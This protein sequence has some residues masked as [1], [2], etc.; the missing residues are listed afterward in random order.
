M[1]QMISKSA[2]AKFK[3]Q[4][5]QGLEPR[6]L[7]EGAFDVMTSRLRKRMAQDQKPEGALPD[8]VRKQLDVLSPTAKDQLRRYLSK[9]QLPSAAMAPQQPPNGGT[10][11]SDQEIEE[12]EQGGDGL[13][14]KICSLLEEYGVDPSIIDRVRELAGDGTLS[15]QHEGDPP[16]FTTKKAFD[17]RKRTAR[18]EEFG[19]GPKR[20]NP[21]GMQTWAIDQ[22]EFPGVP[23]TDVPGP[24]EAS[25]DANR[26]LALD[27]MRRIRV[28]GPPASSIARDRRERKLAQDARDRTKPELGFLMRFPEASRFFN[29]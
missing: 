21:A 15:L 28:D 2:L 17:R 25:G 13:N 5:T 24:F 3:Q 1:Y 20:Y 23:R 27:S 22:P 19:A 6:K 18:D 29:R 7:P 9:D 14:D 10:P 11:M 8:N 4:R 12:E 26:R 16:V